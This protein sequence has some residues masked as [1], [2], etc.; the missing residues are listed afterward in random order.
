MGSAKARWPRGISSRLHHCAEETVLRTGLRRRIR[1]RGTVKNPRRLPSSRRS[2]RSALSPP[3]WATRPSLQVTCAFAPTSAQTNGSWVRR[4]ALPAHASRRA[5]PSSPLSANVQSVRPS[6]GSTAPPPGKETGC[7][8][9]PSAIATS[10][11]GADR[12]KGKRAVRR[13]LILVALQPPSSRSRASI[14]SGQA[15]ASA[16]VGARRTRR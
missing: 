4:D 15:A 12:G 16:P 8:S 11:I 13:P 5:A 10:S 7:S 14:R 1:R 6:A 9:R 3:G 2:R